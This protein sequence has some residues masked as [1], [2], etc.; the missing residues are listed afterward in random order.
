[1]RIWG[2]RLPGSPAWSG[3]E[4]K[5]Y[6]ETSAV[7]QGT[8]RRMNGSFT[9][10]H[11]SS[12]AER[13]CLAALREATEE[14]WGPME[15]HGL[16]VFLIAQR[17]ADHKGLVLDREATFCAAVLHDV[18]LYPRASRGD[19][20]LLDSRRFAEGVLEPFG[21]PPVR[22]GVCLDAIELHHV[23]HQL[24]GF[25]NEAEMIRQADLVEGSAGLLSF[26]L[27]RGW[28]RGDLFRRVPRRGFYRMFAW[29]GA[30]ALVNRPG[31]LP[32]VFHPRG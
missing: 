21:W 8:G 9:E 16:R 1:L 15:R 5:A 2:T 26:G 18:G 31:T 7:T 17:L 32:K 24:W 22:L 11:A 4:G 6:S 3:P 19:V 20:Y 23:P 14:S 30:R 25:G 12:A 28:L 13:A 27:P 10:K 29:H